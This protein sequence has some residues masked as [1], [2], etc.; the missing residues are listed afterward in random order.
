MTSSGQIKWSKIK[1]M[2]GACAPGYLF[3]EFEHYCRIIYNGEVYWRL[4]TGEH[5]NKNPEIER[6]H[7]QKMIRVL[8]IDP[9]CAKKYLTSIHVKG[10]KDKP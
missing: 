9:A 4:P 1:T 5:G 8:N 6:G 7:I 10:I 3:K 2:L